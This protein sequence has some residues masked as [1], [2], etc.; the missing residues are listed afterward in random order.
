MS[1]SSRDVAKAAADKRRNKPRRKLEESPSN[2]NTA[3]RPRRFDNL[4]VPETK[5]RFDNLPVPKKW[6]MD[7]PRSNSGGSN[8]ETQHFGPGNG[9]YMDMLSG[10]PGA[11]G[12]TPRKWRR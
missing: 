10:H 9:S 5:K 12:N 6:R 4:P 11:T 7:S 1:I 8:Y 3:E 2:S